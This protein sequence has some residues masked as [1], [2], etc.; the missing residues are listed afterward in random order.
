MTTV[1]PTGTVSVIFPFENPLKLKPELSFVLPAINV[2]STVFV[3]R[4]VPASPRLPP[5]VQAAIASA[6]ARTIGILNPV[7]V[8]DRPGRPRESGIPR[9]GGLEPRTMTP[10]FYFLMFTLTDAVT[11][12]FNGS[13]ALSTS[14]T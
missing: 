12:G 9:V 2:N 1:Q 10:A 11:A 8:L 4:G 13:C 5:V 3:T 14:T 7:T 6:V